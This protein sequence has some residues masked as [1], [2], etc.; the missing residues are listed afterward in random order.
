MHLT[1]ILDTAPVTDPE[2]E[3]FVVFSQDIPSQS[4]GFIDSQVATLDVTIAGCDL[5]IHQS[6]GLL[7]SDRKTGTTGAVV[8]KVTPLFSSWISSPTNFLFAN[9]LLTNTSTAL[10][11]GAGVSGIVALSLGPKIARYTAT[12]QPYVLKLLKQNIAENLDVVLP[13]TQ[14]K[15]GRQNTRQPNSVNERIQARALDWETDD[16]SSVGDVDVLIACD[17]IYNE[18]LIEPLNST[19]ASVCRLRSLQDD[20]AQNP[21]LC[22]IAQQLRSPDVFEAWLKSFHEKFYVWQIPDRLLSEGLREGSGFVV[23][24][25][26]V[27]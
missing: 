15:N 22:I 23:H 25:G 16:V 12:D 18:S 8:W 26:I 20:D 13:R 11:L 14:R 2:E 10:E 9:N 27:R 5:T 4:L 7:T 3:A 6:R 24:I 17:C 1:R 21:T 19:C